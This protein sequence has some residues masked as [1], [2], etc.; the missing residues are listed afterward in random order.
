MKSEMSLMVAKAVATAGTSI[1]VFGLSWW[2]IAAA[3]IGAFASFHFEPE[4]R[5]NKLTGLIFGIFSTAFAAAFLAAAIPHFP[6]MGW[7]AG[8]VVEVRA[9]LLGLCIRFIFEQFRRV[10]RGYKQSG[11]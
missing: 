4:H 6:M 1:A 9:G 10:G 3:T 7:T 5:P 11:V 2:A 8:I